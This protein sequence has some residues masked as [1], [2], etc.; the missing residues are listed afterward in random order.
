MQPL[1]ATDRAGR[2][3]AIATALGSDF[4][5]VIQSSRV[6]FWTHKRSADLFD[7]FTRP[8]LLIDCEEQSNQRPNDICG[9]FYY[10]INS[11]VHHSALGSPETAQGRSTLGR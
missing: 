10:L 3:P 7:S 9:K 1:S 2:N 11:A 6:A 4:Y 5:V 8:N